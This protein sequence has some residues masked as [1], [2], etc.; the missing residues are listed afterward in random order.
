M[1]VQDLLIRNQ[2]L[3]KH[4]SSCF[5]QETNN[6]YHPVVLMRG[7]GI[8]VVGESVAESVF[9]AIYT[10]ENAQ[11]QTASLTLQL[12]ASTTAA[13]PV[14]ALCYLG[15]SELHAT[16]QMTQRSVIRPWNLWVHEVEVN[17]LY[18]N[19]AYFIV[20]A[21][22]YVKRRSKL[23]IKSYAL[24]VLILCVYESHLQLPTIVVEYLVAG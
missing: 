5:S 4:L 22:S 7:H 11:I 18:T 10:V 3:G 16:T 23:S 21:L 2:R 14:E 1:D 15:D 6:S 24:R 17:R 19:N 8:T 9:R 13:A 20:A 12:A